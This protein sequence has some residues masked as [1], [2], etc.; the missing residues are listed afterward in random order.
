MPET[1]E[2]KYLSQDITLSPNSVPASTT[3]PAKLAY[4]T[5]GSPSDPAVLLPT[6]YGGTLASTLP[7]L[8][9]DPDPVFPTDKYFIV[10]TALLGGGESSSPFNTPAPY[11]GPRFPKVTY[12]DNIRLQY[13][14]C[15]ELGVEKLKA[16]I[17]FS[18]GG[19]Q[20]YHMAALYPD[21]VEHVVCIAGSAK[22]SAHNWCLLE[23]P[24]H[25]LIMSEDFKGGEYRDQ[26]PLKGQRAFSRVYSTWALSQGWFREKSWEALGFKSLEEY[27]EAYWSGEKSD[28]NGLLA[29]LWTWQQGDI[30]LYHSEDGDDLGKA[31]ARIKAKALVMPSRTDMYFPPEDSEYEV[32]HLKSGE[33]KVI[34]TVWGHVAGGGSGTKDDTEFMKKEIKRFVGA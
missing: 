30:G 1:P 16:Y 21:F 9:S 12:E 7:L 18:M 19:Q 23:G 22:T 6:C 28:A 25:A 33:L 17:G 34:E 29:L 24:K 14:L 4:W 26:T 27:L 31:L 8:Y 5:F 2:T 3:F 13:A 10:V 20:S 15:K 11:D 32:K